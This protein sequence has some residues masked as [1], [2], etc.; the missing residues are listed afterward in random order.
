MRLRLAKA[1]DANALA[2]IHAACF[3]APWNASVFAEF[4]RA[5][6]SFAFLASAG[7]AFAGFILCRVIADE[8]E[9]LTLAILPSQRRR[10]LA[11]RLL[12]AGAS[13]AGARGATALFLEVA[14]DNLPAVALYRMEL[15]VSV[16]RRAGYYAAS[17]ETPV[18]ALVMRRALN[19]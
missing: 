1:S 18:D 13:V 14:D 10:G 6:G 2:R 12:A 7:R 8:A 16:G 11:R 15:F 5:G 4:L 17:G 9:V 3:A 19:S